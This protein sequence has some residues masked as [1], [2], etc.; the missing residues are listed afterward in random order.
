MTITL[1]RIPVGDLL[2]KNNDKPSAMITCRISED[3]NHTLRLEAAARRITVSDL[4]R[5]KLSTPS[6]RK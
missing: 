6:R 1:I 4:V 2:K 5:E 3:L